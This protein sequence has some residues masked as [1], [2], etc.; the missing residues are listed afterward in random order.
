MKSHT[1]YLTFNL[2]A[3]VGFQRITDQVQRIVTD[4]GIAEGLVLANAKHI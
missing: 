2:P 4:S 3:R 1:A